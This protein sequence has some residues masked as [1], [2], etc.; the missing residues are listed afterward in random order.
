MEAP[1]TRTLISMEIIYIMSI[2]PDD[3]NMNYACFKIEI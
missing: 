2:I 1:V 3:G